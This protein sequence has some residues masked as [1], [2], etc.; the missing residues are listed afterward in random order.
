[1]AAPL[2]ILVV[3]D[4]WLIAEDLSDGLRRAGHEVVACVPSVKE[5]LAAIG[6]EEIDVALLDVQ[7]NHQTSFAIADALSAK[8]VPFA[9]LTGYTGDSL[10]ERF[11][12]SKILQ[13]PTAQQFVMSALAE[14][15]LIN[16]AGK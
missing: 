8:G 10:P 6:S 12:T 2:R 3:E 11:A 16:P 5:A 14:L 9:F 1:M 13:K 4:E 15:G 7:L